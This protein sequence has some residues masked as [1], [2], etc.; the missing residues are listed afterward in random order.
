MSL[1]LEIINWSYYLIL[2]EFQNTYDCQEIILNNEL[3]ELPNNLQGKL[4]RFKFTIFHIV[5]IKLMLD[6]CMCQFV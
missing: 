4:K 6:T 1:Y 3:N 5:N 2:Q